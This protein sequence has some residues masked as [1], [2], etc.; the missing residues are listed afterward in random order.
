MGNVQWQIVGVNQIMY[1]VQIVWYEL[2]C[3][4]YDEYML[5]IQFQV[6][7]MIVVLY[8]LWSLGWDVQQVGVFLFIF[9]MVVV[10]G[11]WIIKVVGDVFVEFFVFFIGDF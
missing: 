1:E 2:F 5:N 4:V 11:Q 7:F 8:I 6:V 9:N 10:S 3:V